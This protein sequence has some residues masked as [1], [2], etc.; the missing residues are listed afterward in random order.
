MQGALTKRGAPI[1]ASGLEPFVTPQLCLA[2]FDTKEPS[3][4]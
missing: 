3:K 4:S 2:H 1:Q